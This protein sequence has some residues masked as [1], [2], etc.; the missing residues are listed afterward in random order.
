MEYWL[1][2]HNLTEEVWIS[3]YTTKFDN[4]WGDKSLLIN[5]KDIN[6]DLWT[7]IRISKSL[8]TQLLWKKKKVKIIVCVVREKVLGETGV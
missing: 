7:K 3:I 1:I 6:S 8:P 5:K 4:Y 2:L